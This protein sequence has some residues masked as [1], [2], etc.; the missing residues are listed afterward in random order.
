L[1]TLTKIKKKGKIPS[2]IQ[3]KIAVPVTNMEK[4]ADKDTYSQLDLIPAVELRI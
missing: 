4:Y 2:N 3:N 1:F